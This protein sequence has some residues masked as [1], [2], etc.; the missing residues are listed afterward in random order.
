VV[1]TIESLMTSDGN[2]ARQSISVQTF[3]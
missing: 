2:S 1:N 3:H